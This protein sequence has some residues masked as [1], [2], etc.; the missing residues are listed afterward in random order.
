MGEKLADTLNRM[1]KNHSY[2]EAPFLDKA[3]AYASY[4]I[5][6]HM[7]KF[8]HRDYRQFVSSLL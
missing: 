1:L 5:K 3:L 6:K 7:Y 8:L 2:L 4:F